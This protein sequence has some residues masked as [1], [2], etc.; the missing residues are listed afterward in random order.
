MKFQAKL[1]DIFLKNTTRKINDVIGNSLQ[2]NTLDDIGKFSVKRIK[3]KTREGYDLSN[4]SVS[5]QPALSKI[6]IYIRKAL[7]NNG[8]NKLPNY[9]SFDFS[10]LTF[11]GQLLN[12]LIYKKT[13]KQNLNGVI[14]T[15]DK[16]PH[17]P[18]RK[19]D[20]SY[21]GNSLSPTNYEIAKR[22]AKSG[23]KFLGLDQEGIKTIINMIQRQFRRDIKNLLTE[24]KG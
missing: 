9:F 23:R 5:R 21:T 11:S 17:K 18:A 16:T 10:N 7:S 22:L 14:L 3:G 12:A 15:V 6:S 19:K 24:K 13:K 8:R 4:K 1:N 20:G 2:V